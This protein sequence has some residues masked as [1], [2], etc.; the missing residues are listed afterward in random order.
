M[1]IVDLA[2]KKWKIIKQENLSSRIKTR[3]ETL[4]FG[5]IEKKKK[6]TLPSSVYFLGDVDIEKVLASNKISFGE[7]TYKYFIGYLYDN[8]K[9]KQLHIMLP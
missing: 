1:K 2:K 3:K 5:N 9:V 7:K 6:K 4:A 8:H